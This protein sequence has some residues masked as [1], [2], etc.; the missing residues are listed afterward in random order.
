MSRR[1]LLDGH[2]CN[3]LES[4]APPPFKFDVYV[5]V[6]KVRFRPVGK[7]ARQSLYPAA[8]NVQLHSVPPAKRAPAAEGPEQVALHSGLAVGISHVRVETRQ[9]IRLLHTERRKI[10]E[11][12][13]KRWRRSGKEYMLR[14]I[15]KAPQGNCPRKRPRSRCDLYKLGIPA[16][17]AVALFGA[18]QLLGIKIGPLAH[19]LSLKREA[20]PGILRPGRPTGE[21]QWNAEACTGGKISYALICF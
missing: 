17:E 2:E 8:G 7:G 21:M 1:I 6:G 19:I 16:L 4:A 11:R 18:A 10:V 3:G 15:L 13:G 20:F 12:I 9:H 5:A 14:H